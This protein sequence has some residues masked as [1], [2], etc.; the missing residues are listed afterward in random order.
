MAQSFASIQEALNQQGFVFGSQITGIPLTGNGA[1]S[2]Q[3]INVKGSPV[4]IFSLAIGTTANTITYR[5]YEDLDYTDETPA[6]VLNRNRNKQ[7]TNKAQFHVFQN[8]TVTPDPA[9]VI[10]QSTIDT[11]RQESINKIIGFE[12][13][14]I[15]KINTKYVLEIVKGG[16]GSSLTDLTVIFGCTGNTPT[17]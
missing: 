4:S 3:A 13:G 12:T 7:N 2:Y 17:N 6:K 10:S 15:L 8:V 11:S 14:I 1:A 16:S 5:L 9:K